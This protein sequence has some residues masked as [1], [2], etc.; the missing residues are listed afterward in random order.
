MSA[1]AKTAWPV[2]AVTALAVLHMAAACVRGA[3]DSPPLCGG[4]AAANPP[5]NITVTY[6]RAD[7]TAFVRLDTGGTA[8]TVTMGAVDQVEAL[9]RLP[10]NEVAI[11]GELTS[12]ASAGHEVA[13]ASLETGTV[14]D[15]WDAYTPV[16]SPDQRWIILRKFYPPQTSLTISEQYLLYPLWRLQRERFAFKAQDAE[17]P[18]GAAVVYPLGQTNTFMSNIGVPPTQVH[19]FRSKS[20]YWSEDSHAIVFADSV[21]DSLNAVLILINDVGT[22]TLIHA[23]TSEDV[24]ESPSPA[25]LSRAT[26]VEAT[27]GRAGGPNGREIQLRFDSG[28]SGCTPK[29]ISIS[30][31]VFQGPEPESHPPGKRKPSTP[32]PQ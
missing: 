8:K 19:V 32:E 14:L 1:T 10:Q 27:V 12:G 5:Q 17:P 6:D 25:F 31:S 30:S 21:Q 29:T 11:F 28:S 23:L 24:C 9:C 16:M 3:T 4:R 20:F 26:L 7:G 13:I 22:T 15:S 2:K 18:S